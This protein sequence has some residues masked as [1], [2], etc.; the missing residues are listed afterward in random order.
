MFEIGDDD[1]IIFGGVN[2]K[3]AYKIN[4]E[5]NKTERLFETT[6]KNTT[7]PV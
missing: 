7:E 4:F 3:T 1:F 6:K 2:N 5:T